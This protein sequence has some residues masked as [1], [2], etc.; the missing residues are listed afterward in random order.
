MP[1][2]NN[3]PATPQAGNA[4]DPQP[5]AGSTPPTPQAGS[6]KTP[7]DYERI[8]AELRK[9][10]AGHRT[11]LKKFEDDEAARSQAQMT[12]QQKLQAE[13]DALQ[14]SNED[15]AAELLEHRVNQDISKLA[16]KFNFTLSSGR[17]SL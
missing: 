17:K 12:E 4:G 15:L 5:Q 16:S 10:N 7:D 14:A 8:L 1:E 9:E 6:G 3:T 13:R 11:K 2:D